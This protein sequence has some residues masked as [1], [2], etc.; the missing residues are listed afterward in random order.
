MDYSYFQNE[1]GDYTIVYKVNDSDSEDHIAYTDTEYK[2]HFIVAALNAY[3][4]SLNP[5]F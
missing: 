2:A 4:L 3:R 5:T 1:Q